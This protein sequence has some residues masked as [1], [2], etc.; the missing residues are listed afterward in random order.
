MLSGPGG[1]NSQREKP[2]SRHNRCV[3]QGGGRHALVGSDIPAVALLKLIDTVRPCRLI[4]TFAAF[5]TRNI[6]PWLPA[7]S[8]WPQQSR[9]RVPGKVAGTDR[10]HTGRDVDNLGRV[11]AKLSIS[12]VIRIGRSDEPG[13]GENAIHDKLDLLRR[14]QVRENPKSTIFFVAHLA[15]WEISALVP[16]HFG[17]DS[18]VLYRRS[19]IGAINNAI[20]KLRARCM[21]ISLRSISTRRS[22]SPR[23]SKTVRT[24]E[25]WLINTSTR[26]SGEA[27]AEASM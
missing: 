13:S 16:P 10:E 15:I 1:T 12:T 7:A 18:Y 3:R 24:S 23:R 19:S 8:C 9:G 17:F 5:L 6:G 22:G 25:C 4:A 14:D 2:Q 27:G 20:L 26:T 11:A 21:G